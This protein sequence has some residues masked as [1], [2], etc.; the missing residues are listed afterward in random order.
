MTYSIIIRE[1]RSLSGELVSQHRDL[2]A[3]ACA[4]AMAQG[5]AD[6]VEMRDEEGRVLAD[7][8]R[9][10]GAHWYHQLSGGAP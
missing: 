1:M 4:F 10:C 5:A 7:Y 9:G 3:A 2:N 8:A 6:Y